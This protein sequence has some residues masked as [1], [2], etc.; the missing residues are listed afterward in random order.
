MN[1][2]STTSGTPRSAPIA[3]TAATSSTSLRALESVSAKSALVRGVIAARH[4]ARSEVST[5]VA[6]MPSREKLSRRRPRV[7]S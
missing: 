3:A 2:L 6:W 7:P 5:K 1:V 4:A